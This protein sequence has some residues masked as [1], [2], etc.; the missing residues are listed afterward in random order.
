MQLFDLGR[1]DGKTLD[2][3]VCIEYCEY[4]DPL[5]LVAEHS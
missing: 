5:E 1:E 3:E 2:F 4:K